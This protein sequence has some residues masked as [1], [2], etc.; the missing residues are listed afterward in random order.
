M[1]Y[2]L[3]SVLLLCQAATVAQKHDIHFPFPERRVLSG[4]YSVYGLQDKGIFFY[5]GLQK[6]SLTKQLT[7]LSADGKTS[8]KSPEFKEHMKSDVFA[9]GDRLT[10][11]STQGHVGEVLV[12][13]FNEQ[14]KVLYN[15][16]VVFPHPVLSFFENDGKVYALLSEY[17]LKKANKIFFQQVSPEGFQPQSQPVEVTLPAYSDKDWQFPGWIFGGCNGN[18][19]M[20][21]WKSHSIPKGTVQYHIAILDKRGKLLSDF[22][23]G[24][25]TEKRFVYSSENRNAFQ[26]YIYPKLAGDT[27]KWVTDTR[28]PGP[29]AFSDVVVDWAGERIYV[30]G[31]YGTTTE[32]GFVI[33]EPEGWFLKQYNFSGEEKWAKEEKYAKKSKEEPQFYPSGSPW[34]IS[35]SAEEQRILIRDFPEHNASLLY[36]GDS[37]HLSKISSAKT[38]EKFQGLGHSIIP[39]NESMHAWYHVEIMDSSVLELAFGIEAATALKAHFR[40]N[41]RPDSWYIIQKHKESFSILECDPVAEQYAVWTVTF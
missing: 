2:H 19:M 31:N 1:K 23:V 9:F 13:Q 4:L 28:T 25:G 22:S 11:I 12:M 3:L 15:A 14:G 5:E 38:K 16:E 10:F 30:F 20:F 18:R 33:K 29:A 21:F 17:K 8:W 7:F 6:M 39:H 40:Q 36:S 27:Y 41:E 24:L 34:G 35:F 32:A 37:L 26:R